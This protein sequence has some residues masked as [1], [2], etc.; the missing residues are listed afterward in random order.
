[1]YN[2]IMAESRKQFRWI[3]NNKGEV[4]VANHDF[5]FEGGAYLTSMGA[6]WFVSYMYF[7]KIDNKH[8][9]WRN[10]KTAENR[11]ST[12]NNTLKYHKFF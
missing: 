12:F 3:F 8:N 10:I 1:M 5:N 4:V 6:S 2:M 11:I 7:K 9:N